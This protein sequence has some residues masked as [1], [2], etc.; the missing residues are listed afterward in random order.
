MTDSMETAPHSGVDYSPSVREAIVATSAALSTDE[1][2]L[3]RRFSRLRPIKLELVYEFTKDPALLH[4]YHE[5]YER[6]FRT[7][8]DA[9]SYHTVEDDH[10]RRAHILVVRR[11]NFCVGGARI[12]ITSPRQPHPLPIE[13]GDFKIDDHFP[14]LRQKELSYGQLGR[15]CLLPEFRGGMIT[16]MMFWHIHRK[17]VAL[18]LSELFGTATKIGVRSYKRDCRAIGLEAK[19]H[20]DIELPTY[21]M[22]D[23]IKFFLISAQLDKKPLESDKDFIDVGSL[24]EEV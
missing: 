16:R 22:C 20:P 4:Q 6:E 18:G 14:Q 21:P 5:I 13:I 23:E 24:R 7:V 1:D 17:S 2:A 10:D 15:F 3:K 8:H 12:N 9:N 19:I 11:G